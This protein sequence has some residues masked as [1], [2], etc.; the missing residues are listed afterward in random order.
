MEIRL[1]RKVALAAVSLCLM[2][3]TVWADD[4]PDAE[5]VQEPNWI[6]SIN[7]GFDIFEY[8]VDAFIKDDATIPLVEGES[9]TWDGVDSNSLTEIVFRVGGELMGPSLD[10]IP[11]R[12]RL[13]IEGGMHLM[14]FQD[15]GI[16]EVGRVGSP[17]TATGGI[18][19]FQKQLTN[20]LRD[21]D[22]P[23]PRGPCVFDD[24]DPPMPI[25]PCPTAEAEQFTD[26]GSLIDGE[27]DDL[28]WY[29]GFGVAFHIPV[30]ENVLLQ[31]KPSVVYNVEK[32]DFTGKIVTVNEIPVPD[33]STDPLDREQFEVLRGS[34]TKSNTYHSLGMGL[35]LGMV[36]FPDA[37]PVRTTVFLHSRFMWLLSNPTSSWTTPTDGT[38]TNPE[39]LAEAS[40]SVTR[41]DFTIRG[42][43]GVRFS[44][45]GYGGS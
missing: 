39:G 6:P 23:G 42:G 44:W 18:D 29:A 37:R 35:E 24:P 1:G 32:I 9:P 21:P 41:D 34:G 20:R 17:E 38:F 4:E 33:G 16:M 45:M 25:Q 10:S 3:Q 13:F 12:P 31:F 40:Y 11:G 26:Q 8:D 36:L 15:R 22:G 43:F 28:S 2:G 19:Q 14:A 30:S 27:F 5:Q 7:V